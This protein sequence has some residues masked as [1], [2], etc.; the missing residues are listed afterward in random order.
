MAQTSEA[1]I[2]TSILVDYLRQLPPAVNFLD[3]LNLPYISAITG[4]EIIQGSRSRRELEVNLSFL[5]NFRIIE[6]DSKI[7]KTAMSLLKK[8]QLKYNAKI[9]DTFI[10]ATAL[11][12]NKILFTRNIKDFDFID[13]IN[14]KLPY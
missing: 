7:S 13:G 2:D 1:L 3:S 5:K 10:A 6:I 11:N 9:L 4:M 12:K 8:Y 14:V